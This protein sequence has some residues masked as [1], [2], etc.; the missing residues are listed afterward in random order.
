MSNPAEYGLAISGFKNIVQ[1]TSKLSLLK[2]G[3]DLTVSPSD[4]EEGQTPDATDVRFDQGGVS[5]DHGITAFSTPASA[6]DLNVMAVAPFELDNLTK[7]MMRVRPTRLD[8]WN[9]TNWLELTGALTGTSSDH[10]YTTIA[11]GKF[12]VANLVDRLKAWDG[13]DLNAVADL[14]VDAPI[15]RFITRLGT[16]ILAAV[17]KTGGVIDRYAVAWC[18]DGLITDWTTSLSG[19]GNTTL[20][21]EGSGKDAGFITGLGTLAG[22]AVVFRQKGLTLAQA[23]GVGAAPVRF[24]TIDFQHGTESP[25]SIAGGSLRAGLYWLGEDYMVYHFDGSSLP[26]PIGLPIYSALQTQ[27]SDRA[28]VRGAVDTKNHEFWL[29]IPTDDTGLVKLAYVFSIREW[30][31]SGRLVWRKRSLGSGYRTVGFGYTPTSSD[32]I[33]NTVLNIVDTID[34]RPDSYA[35]TQADER[36][37]FGD[38]VGQ[39]YYVDP[40][41]PITSGTWVSKTLGDGV[42]EVTLGYAAIEVNSQ[43]GATVELSVSM[44]NGNTWIA[45]RILTVP[46]E[47]SPSVSYTFLDVTGSLFQFRLRILSG[48]V[49]ISRIYYQYDNRGRAH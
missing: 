27:I 15:A 45:P 43:V 46:A 30:V 39:V 3:L 8:R 41:S 7:L 4:L 19:A 29:S 22:G 49:T 18:A 1:E 34:K 36:V 40:T 17:I 12:I 13:V 11:S 48:F 35:N 24:T 42:T 32:P 9:G 38:T 20:F 37:L 44:D 6:N 23:T 25:Y 31:A 28:L 5:T 14:S 26:T 33:V 21:P 47:K 2:G 16:R 10:V